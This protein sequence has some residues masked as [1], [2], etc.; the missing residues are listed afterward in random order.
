MVR[1]TVYLDTSSWN[2]LSSGQM[3]SLRQ[4]ISKSDTCI[5]CYST[6]SIEELLGVC[7]EEKRVELDLQLDVVGARYIEAISDTV[8]GMP[9][10]C[11]ITVKSREERSQI[12][13]DMR[14]FSSTG[15]FGLGDFLQKLIGGIDSTSFEGIFKMGLTDIERLLDFDVSEFPLE[16]AAMVTSAA[17][18]KKEQARKAQCDLLEHLNRK[19]GIRMPQLDP[20]RINNFTGAGA[21]ER[22]FEAAEVHEDT[23]NMVEAFLAGPPRISSKR[24]EA[25]LGTPSWEQVYRLAQLLFLLGYWRESKHRKDTERARIDFAGGQAD[26]CHIAN[27]SFCSVFHTSD[28]PQARL[29]AAVY[30][31]L[32]VPTM[33]LL[34]TPKTDDEVTLYTPTNIQVMDG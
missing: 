31:H 16:L 12:Y 30:D 28:K 4:I 11:E 6:H 21:I 15:G 27:A 33:V 26:I 7:D 34:Y 9:A 10:G 22:I 23:S 8:G 3:S 20:A 13:E 18:V 1:L 19:E 5:P 17:E 24:I 29:A 25:H 32:N 14:K 2:H